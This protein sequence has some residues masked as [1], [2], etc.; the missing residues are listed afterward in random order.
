MKTIFSFFATFVMVTLCTVLTACGSDD[1]DKNGNNLVNPLVGTWE[2]VYEY[3]GNVEIWTLTFYANN[4]Y[5]FIEEFR[6]QHEGKNETKGTYT[7]DP[8]AK[9]LTLK[10]SGDWDTGI[11]QISGNKLRI[12]W[13]GE[14][15]VEY[16]R[17]K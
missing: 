3:E 6:G 11:V 16:I 12:D 14:E 17:K 4:T 5:L 9:E 1:E 13:G 2:A 15:S 7:Y 10:Y 8:D